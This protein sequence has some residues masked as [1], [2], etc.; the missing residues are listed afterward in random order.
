MI[1]VPKLDYCKIGKRIQA[2]DAF[3]FDMLFH[4][5]YQPV[6]R[7]AFAMLRNHCDADDASQEVFIKLWQKI[8]KWDAALGSFIGW[9]LILA[10]R[11]IIDAYRKQQRHL[12]RTDSLD[13]NIVDSVDDED[14]NIL[15]PL[16]L[17]PDERPDTLG[18]IIAD[19]TMRRIE[20]TVISIENRRHRLAWILRNFEGY[21]LREISEIMGSPVGSCKVWIH[22]CQN[23]MR[24]VLEEHIEQEKKQHDKRSTLAKS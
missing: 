17:V 16:E 14:A 13:K 12:K 6:Y 20:E 7:R 4:Q 18:I 3:A 2:D 24:A 1:K 11:S 9:F 21:P 8:P 23:E 10:E 15:T 5:L 22:R 19:E